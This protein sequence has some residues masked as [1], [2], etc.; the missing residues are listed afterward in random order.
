MYSKD[1]E[2]AI[3]TPI[4][5]EEKIKYDNT[6]FSLFKEQSNRTGKQNALAPTS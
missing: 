6:N 1:I 4:Y 3:Q 2:W 5:K